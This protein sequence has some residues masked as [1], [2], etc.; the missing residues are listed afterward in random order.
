MSP[1]ILKRSL[2]I[3]VH[4]LCPNCWLFRFQLFVTINNIVVNTFVHEA[5]FL[6]FRAVSL[7]EGP[8]EVTGAEGTGLKAP[9]IQ[10]S[11]PWVSLLPG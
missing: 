5:F 4:L 1:F 11:V 10:H 7:G 6:I 2:Q 8:T 3:S 9:C